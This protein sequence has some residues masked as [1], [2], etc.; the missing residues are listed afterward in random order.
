MKRVFDW[1]KGSRYTEPLSPGCRLC[2]E[3]A[4]MV[5]LVTGRCSA[6]CFYCPLSKKKLGK[7]VVYANEWQLDN[8]DDIDKLFK[9]AKYI[10]AKGAGVTGGDPLIVWGRTKRYISLLKKRFGEDFHIHLYT[11]GVKGSEHI[12]DL[13]SAGLDEIRFH[14]PPQFWSNMDSSPTKKPVQIALAE[15]VDVAIEIPAIP[16]MDAEIL[17][18]IRWADEHGLK[19]VNLNELEFSETNCDELLKRGFDVKND[20]SAAAKGSEETAY[21]VVDEAARNDPEVGVHYCSS[22]FKDGV[23]LRN[24]IMRRARNVAKPFEVVSDDGTLLKGV[25][26]SD[27]V[28]PALVEMLKQRFG[29]PDGL[30]LFDEEKRRVELAGWILEEIAS[31]LKKQGFECYLVEEYPTADRLEVERIP[32]PD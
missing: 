8:E 21:H 19:W 13:A 9:E 23:Q 15:D 10:E 24:R 30:I 27:S 22:S 14:P 18:L 12:P 28:S 11:S 25:I 5:L 6:H 3:G 1:L 29:I 2:A 32:L 4:K 26:V 7:D 17:S 31:E 16:N 20:I